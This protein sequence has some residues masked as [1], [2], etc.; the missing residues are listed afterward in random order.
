MV[1][2]GGGVAGGGTRGPRNRRQRRRRRGRWLRLRRTR[3]WR[4]RLRHRLPRFLSRGRGEG[5]E[6]HKAGQELGA[7]PTAKTRSFPMRREA[8]MG[9]GRGK[10]GDRAPGN[11]VESVLRSRDLPSK[12]RRASSRLAGDPL[13][14]RLRG[15]GG[16]GWG[17]GSGRQRRRPRSR[18]PRAPARR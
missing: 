15:R 2:G 8:W 1:V 10:G 4:Q 14:L 11:L 6:E 7:G 16:R 9:G 13:C 3:S 17:R 18:T 5:R 12:G